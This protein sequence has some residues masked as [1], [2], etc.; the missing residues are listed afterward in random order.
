MLIY[1]KFLA[2]SPL[3]THVPIKR[4][5]NFIKK[6]TI[7]K[8]VIKIDNFYKLNLKKVPNIAVLGLNPHCE[9]TDKISEEK[10]EIRPAIKFLKTKKINISGPFSADTFFLK[11]NLVK[12]DVV[13]GMYHD[14]VLVPAKTLFN[15][16]AINVTLGLPFIKIT[17]DH[18]PNYQ[19]LGK[20]KSDSSSIFYA[21]NFLNEI[22]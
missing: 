16:E 13:V 22:R 7:I 20:N 17:P 19:M 2:V 18:G 8:N 9:T 6:R 15:F 5:A 3:T 11:K 4:V 1:N 10:K 21:F 14:Q 12:F